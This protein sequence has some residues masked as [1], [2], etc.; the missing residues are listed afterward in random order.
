MNGLFGNF[1]MM[2]PQGGQGQL[3]GFGRGSGGYMMPNVQV[4]QQNVANYLRMPV[5]NAPQ[6]PQQPSILDIVKT[7]YPEQENF[8]NTTD[9]NPLLRVAGLPLNQPKQLPPSQ[10]AL[11]LQ[12][13]SGYNGNTTT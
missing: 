13:I 10:E 9:A 11:M 12:R 3:S 2:N 6:Q 8:F 5:M 7:A 1:S 4:P